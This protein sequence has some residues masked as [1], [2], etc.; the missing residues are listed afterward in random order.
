VNK[1]LFVCEQIEARASE[2]E[3]TVCKLQRDVDRLEG[4]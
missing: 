1:W 3:R 2:S 4:K